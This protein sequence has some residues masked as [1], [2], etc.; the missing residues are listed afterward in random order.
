VMGMPTLKKKTID[1]R[2]LYCPG[3]IE[4]LNNIFKQLEKGVVV[5]VLA[6]DPDVKQDITVWCEKTGNTLISFTEKAG[7]LTFLIR[8]S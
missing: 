8:K 1:V 4:V 5:E 3:P 2:G 6:D 7:I